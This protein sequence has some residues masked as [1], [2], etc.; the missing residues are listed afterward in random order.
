MPPPKPKP[1]EKPGEKKFGLLTRKGKFLV[2]LLQLI[3]LF[4]LASSKECGYQQA[5]IG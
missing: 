1:A 4:R 2:L 5:Q 3:P